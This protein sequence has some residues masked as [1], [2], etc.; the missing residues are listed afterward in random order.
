MYESYIYSFTVSEHLSSRNSLQTNL[1]LYALSNTAIDLEPLNA[2]LYTWNLLLTLELEEH[3][4]WLRK[5]FKFYGRFSIWIVP[6]LFIVLTF[7]SALAMYNVFE[8]EF[9]AN[10]EQQIF[11]IH[12]YGLTG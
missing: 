5:T 7:A 11:W 2:F 9:Q 8:A 10:S 6:L 3:N 1:V 12:V 4:T